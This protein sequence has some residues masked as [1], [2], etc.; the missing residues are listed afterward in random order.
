MYGE[1][2]MYKSFVTSILLNG[3]ETWTLLTDS[4]KK[5]GFRE[6]LLATVKRR[7]LAWFGHV[8]RHDSLSKTVLQGTLES[9][10]DMRDKQY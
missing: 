8:T 4:K 2:K 9:A 6:P 10:E 1:F 5:K 7:K 3:C